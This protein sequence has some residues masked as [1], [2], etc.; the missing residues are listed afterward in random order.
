[1]CIGTRQVWGQVGLL[2]CQ[3]YVLLN[4][5]LSRNA[6][7]SQELNAEFTYSR[8]LLTQSILKTDLRDF[9]IFF[10]VIWVLVNTSHHLVKVMNWCTTRS[11][12]NIN[13]HSVRSSKTGVFRN[14]EEFVWIWNVLSVK[15]LLMFIW[16]YLRIDDS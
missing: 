4:L 11:P 14:K 9:T 10:S 3:V 15:L 5:L 12:Q 2:L 16:M 7:F 8:W 1:M 13:W 6:S